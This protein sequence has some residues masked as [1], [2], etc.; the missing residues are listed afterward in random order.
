MFYMEEQESVMEYVC[1]ESRRGGNCR[2]GTVREGE[3]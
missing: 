1:H 3:N 2:G